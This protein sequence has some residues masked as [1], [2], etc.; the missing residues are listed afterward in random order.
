[1][2]MA[3]RAFEANIVAIKA[4]RQMILKALEIGR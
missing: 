3:R 1:M 4:A 2:L